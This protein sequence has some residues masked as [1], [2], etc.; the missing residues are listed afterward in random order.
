MTVQRPHGAARVLPGWGMRLMLGWLG[1]VGVACGG[2]PLDRTGGAAGRYLG[3]ERSGAPGAT[4]AEQPALVTVEAA[5]GL[6]G[7]VDA[8]VSADAFP[9]TSVP[10]VRSGSRLKLEDDHTCTVEFT[11]TAP[12]RM[13]TERTTYRITRLEV[14]VSGSDLEVEATWEVTE[15]GAVPSVTEYTFEGERISHE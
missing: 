14:D 15:D 8:W 7:D 12:T 5:D 2:G 6:G 3:Q 10:V 11:Q 9:C 1:L 13:P 4:P